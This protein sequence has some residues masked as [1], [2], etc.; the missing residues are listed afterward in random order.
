[1]NREVG[2]Q[3]QSNREED[4]VKFQKIIHQVM[5]SSFLDERLTSFLAS[6]GIKTSLIYN[7]ETPFID[8]VK[9]LNHFITC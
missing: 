7:P 5:I 4:I 1:V 2:D 9:S 6:L 3:Q 8:M